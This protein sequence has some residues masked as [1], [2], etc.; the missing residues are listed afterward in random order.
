MPAAD[1]KS[2]SFPRSCRLKSSLVIKNVVHERQS[3]FH[4]PIKCFYHTEDGAGPVSPR[5]AVLVSKKRLRH[6]TDRNRVKRLM[7]EAYRLHF[8]DLSLPEDCALSM[9]WM[10]VGTEKPDF[11]QVENAAIEILHQLRS[12]FLMGKGQ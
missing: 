9:C 8:R 11:P 2:C 1:A 7:R 12:R 6:A 4:Y 3:V 10:F 5:M